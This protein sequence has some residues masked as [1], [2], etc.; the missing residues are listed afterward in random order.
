MSHKICKIFIRIC[1]AENLLIINIDFLR[2]LLLNVD[3]TKFSFIL[4]DRRATAAG[5]SS[6]CVT[7]EAKHCY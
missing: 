5:I 4:S 2:L 1:Y 3:T 6:G 7:L